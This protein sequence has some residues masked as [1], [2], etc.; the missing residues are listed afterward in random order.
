[1]ASP[2]PGGAAT[3]GSTASELHPHHAPRGPIH[4]RAGGSKPRRFA[5]RGRRDQ[6][7]LAAWRYTGGRAQME[8]S[9]SLKV[10]SDGPS[11]RAD[12]AMHGA[13]ARAI[14][15]DCSRG[16]V[17]PRKGCSPAI[18]TRLWVLRHRGPTPWQSTIP[19]QRQA[20]MVWAASPDWAWSCCAAYS[21]SADRWDS[22]CALVQSRL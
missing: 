7:N 17:Q 15:G 12:I 14:L 20:M 5:L 3:V 22:S 9:C 19:L 2:T 18:P 16:D 10:R 1:M 21:R 13:L 4:H 8:T 6:L 11:A